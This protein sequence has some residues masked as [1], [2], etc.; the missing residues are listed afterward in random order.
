MREE[1]INDIAKKV[2]IELAKHDIKLVGQITDYTA[3]VESIYSNMTSKAETFKKEYRLKIDTLQKPLVTL[4]AK[5]AVSSIEFLEKT[6][7]LGIDGKVTTPYKQYQK[8][9]QDVDKMND[10]YKKEYGRPI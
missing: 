9:I 7:N 6:K 1:I 10:Y 3:E 4:R 2:M 5:I 8:L